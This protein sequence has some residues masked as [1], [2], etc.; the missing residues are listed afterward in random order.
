LSSLLKKA[1]TDDVV[2]MIC[3]RDLGKTIKGILSNRFPRHIQNGD[4]HYTPAAVLVPIF[5]TNDEYHLLF[6][7]RASSVKYHQG[8]ISFPG[9]VVIETDRSPEEA[10]LRETY[11]EIGLL[12]NDVEILGPIDDSLTFVP[13]FIVHPFVG[14]I[15]HSYTFNINPKEVEKTIEVPLRFF[16]S[17]VSK[18]DATPAEFER[19]IGYPEYRYNGELIWGT[20]ASIVVNF[21]RILMSSSVNNGLKDIVDFVE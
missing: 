18:D 6:T 2:D 15:P 21:L 11:E 5:K 20:T 1:F 12:K 4:L 19:G 7:K 10:A 3:T 14:L 17:Q 8:H 16:A 9:G 13:P